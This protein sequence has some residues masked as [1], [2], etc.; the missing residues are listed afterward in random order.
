MDE[1]FMKQFSG[2]ASAN[3]LTVVVVGLLAISEVYRPRVP[4]LKMH[5]LLFIC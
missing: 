4:P 2:S 3:L 5:F 1:E